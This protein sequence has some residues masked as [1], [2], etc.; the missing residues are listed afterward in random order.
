M[1]SNALII[2]LFVFVTVMFLVLALTSGATSQAAVAARQRLEGFTR[3]QADT[4]QPLAPSFRERVLAPMLRGAANGLGRLLPRSM[5]SGV[6]KSLVIAGEPMTLSGFLTMVLIASG[7]ALFLG[8]LIV[9]VSGASFGTM[10]LGIIVVVALIGFFMPF[11][12]IKSRAR[13]RQAAV[14]KS[15]ADAFD[16]ITT[17]VEAGLGLDAALARV[18]EKV[19]GPFAVE[20]QRALRDIALGK[21]RRDALKELGE[22]TA[23]PDLLQ[24]T[25]AVVQAEAMGSSIGT[26]LRV[27][28]DQLRVRRRQRAEEAAYKAPI[29]MLFPLVLCIF[30]TL[31]IVILGPA[32]ITIMQDF[33]S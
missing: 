25:N 9:F 19:P 30:P 5:L 27:Q 3:N 17:C 16:L 29:K 28:S 7:S 6:E 18:A 26:V 20:L 14:V 15:L 12:M 2:A 1:D 4:M 11:Y 8:V 10:Q 22:R 24:F 31:F 13:Q 21:S 23:V 32:I 33:P